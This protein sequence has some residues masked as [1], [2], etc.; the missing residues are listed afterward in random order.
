MHLEKAP[1]AVRQKRPQSIFI[2]DD[3]QHGTLA[4]RKALERGLKVGS[5]AQNRPSVPRKRASRLGGHGPATRTS[6]KHHVESALKRGELRRSGTRRKM[7]GLGRT[8]N[9]PG[10]LYRK[11]QSKIGKI[12]TNHE[13]VTTPNA[14]RTSRK[15]PV[16]GFSGAGPSKF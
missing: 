14:F 3:A 16:S 4:T 5:F 2:R 1:E 7:H 10:A 11:H 9:A 8:R 12:K 6:K 15:S 13:N